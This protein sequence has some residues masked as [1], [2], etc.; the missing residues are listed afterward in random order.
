MALELKRFRWSRSSAYSIVTK[1]IGTQSGSFA[2]SY[3]GKGGVG[4][5]HVQ[6]ATD[7]ILP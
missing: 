6:G 4:I 3:H 1:Q 7:T 5:W 2:A